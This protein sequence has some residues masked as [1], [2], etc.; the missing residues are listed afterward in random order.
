M[1]EYLLA[2]PDAAVIILDNDSTYPPLLD[3]YQRECRVEVVRVGCNGGPYALWKH[4][5]RSNLQ[6]ISRGAEN[7]VLTDSDLD[8]SLV[9]LDVLDVLADGLRTHSF[10]IKAGLS[11]EIIGIPERNRGAE[12]TYW[13]HRVDRMWWRAVV[14]TTFAM[15]R[16]G[17]DWGGYGPAIRSDRPYTARHLP[18]YVTPDNITEEDQYYLS[19]CE[20]WYSTW[21]GCSRGFLV[22]D[23]SRE[24]AVSKPVPRNG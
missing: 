18:Y 1:A 13:R 14:D 19:H 7:Y 15:Y 17:S 22:H 23:S 10:A 5:Y 3:W 6:A 9:P 12:A 11:L 24:R 4:V 16:H 20:R 2:I 21:K 8:L